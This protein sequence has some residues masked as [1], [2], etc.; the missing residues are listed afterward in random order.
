MSER[1]IT[2]GS[3]F[4][5]GITFSALLHVG[6]FYLVYFVFG[7]MEKEIEYVQAELWSG[8]YADMAQNQDGVASREKQK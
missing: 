8:E 5:T 4:R 3:Y 1:H 7:S 6:I 2:T